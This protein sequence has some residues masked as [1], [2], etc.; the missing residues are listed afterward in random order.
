M[1]G[2]GVPLGSPS[3]IRSELWG[4]VE[5][6]AGNCSL[7]Q[8]GRAFWKTRGGAG[9]QIQAAEG[10]WRSMGRGAR[11]PGGRR[12]DRGRKGAVSMEDG[13]C[14]SSLWTVSESSRP[15]SCP[16]WLMKPQPPMG[17][18]EF[19]LPFYSCCFSDSQKSGCEPVTW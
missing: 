2:R 11:A 10:R 12:P 8:S 6:S 4:T 7:G 9:N 17:W 19:S 15:R 14:S 13:D 18:A 1:L 16:G 3:S 5:F